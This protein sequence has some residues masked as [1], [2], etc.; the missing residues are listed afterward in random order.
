MVQKEGPKCTCHMGVERD[1]QQAVKQAM[2]PLYP[3]ASRPPI[4]SP[5]D[6]LDLIIGVSDAVIHLIEEVDDGVGEVD[7][8]SLS[9]SLRCGRRPE[10]RDLGPGKVAATIPSWSLRSDH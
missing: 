8:V 9:G 7:S 5:R 6:Q 2:R 1:Y 3:V 4:T 10:Q